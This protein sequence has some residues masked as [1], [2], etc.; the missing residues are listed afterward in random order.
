MLWGVFVEITAVHVLENDDCIKE[1]P[2]TDFRKPSYH[3]K[4]EYKGNHTP[5][6]LTPHNEILEFLTGVSNAFQQI[7]KGSQRPLHVLVFLAEG[8][9]VLDLHLHPLYVAV[10][11]YV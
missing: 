11:L 7:F 1:E 6:R 5:P 8:L 10:L 4:K 2:E 9:G 3:Q